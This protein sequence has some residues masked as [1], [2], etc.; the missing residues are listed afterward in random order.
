MGFFLIIRNSDFL[1]KPE[2]EKSEFLS[3]A[4]IG[5]FLAPVIP[6]TGYICEGSLF[7]VNPIEKCTHFAI[8]LVKFK[9]LK[10]FKNLN[11]SFK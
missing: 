6:K 11:S 8:V 4:E 5:H 9:N 3:G 2:S 10:K 1:T 7:Q